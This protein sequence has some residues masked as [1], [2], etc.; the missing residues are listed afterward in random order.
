MTVLVGATGPALPQ[1]LGW[2]SA[3]RASSDMPFFVDETGE[4]FIK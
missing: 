1:F 3:Y 4:I 2:L